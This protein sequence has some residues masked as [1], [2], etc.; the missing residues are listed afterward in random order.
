[1]FKDA[2]SLEIHYKFKSKTNTE[3]ITRAH[4]YAEGND[5]IEKDKL[6]M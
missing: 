6:I 5:L 3:G 2:I 1:L 4:L